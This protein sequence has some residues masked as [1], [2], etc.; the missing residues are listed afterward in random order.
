MSEKLN[1]RE[2]INRSARIG[3]AAIIGKNV[4]GSLADGPLA[5]R[6]AETIDLA[7]VSGS[8]YGAMA[9]KAV[10]MLGGMGRFVPKGAKVFAEPD[11]IVVECIMP[12]VEEEEA[13]AEPLAG[14]PEVSGRKKEEEGEAEE[15]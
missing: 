5:A 13:A 4:L 12:A 2:F 10:G 14:E 1:R 9:A 15:E 3:A 11:D 7:V 8:D 6:A